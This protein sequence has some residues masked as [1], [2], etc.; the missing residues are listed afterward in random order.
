MALPTMG[1]M[2]REELMASTSSALPPNI[3]EFNQFAAVVFAQLYIAH[4]KSL[5]VGLAPI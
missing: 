3:Q 2:M 4:R 1:S 5:L